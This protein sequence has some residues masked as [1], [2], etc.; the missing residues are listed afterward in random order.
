MSDTLVSIH[1][2]SAL[3]DAQRKALLQRTES[4]LSA[5]IDKV[6]PI[7]EAVRIDG[8]AALADFARQFDKAQVAADQ[9]RATTEEFSAARASIDPELI[10]TLEFAAGNIRH[11]HE[12]QMPETL[13]LHET[14]RGVLVGDRW[15]AIDSVACY[16]PRG[17]GS[18]PS[19]VLM[20]AIPAKVA[21]VRKVVIITPPGPDGTVDPATL[22]AA[23]IAG[24]SD[25]FKCGGAQ[26]IAAVAFGT[27]TVPKCDK[28]VGPG[29]PWVVAAKKQLSSL[30]DPGSPA[31]PSELIIFSDGSV[32]AELVALDLCVESEHGPDSSVFFVTDNADFANAVAS[33]VPAL[34]SRMGNIRAQYSKTVLSGPRGGIVIARTRADALA[35]V[36]DYAPEHLA[37]LA[38]NAWQYLAC[39]EHAG[40]ILLGPHSAISVANFVL[41]PSH[42]LPT[43]GAAKTT[44]PLSVFD[45]LKRTSIASLSKEAY[46]GFAAHAERLARYEGFDGHANAVST[47]RDEALRSAAGAST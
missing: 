46:G 15:N 39:F 8:D 40:E 23:E 26:A 20:T 36:N 47:I 5:F 33:C 6:N 44:S 3:D 34:W 13:V 7:I 35:F 21:G 1:T 2:L 43:G 32:P 45:F 27:Q 17:K 41:G 9:L 24:V 10:T 37:V 29:S 14:H 12:K 30:I 4:D 22:V 31:G 38:D 18:F 19:S 16:V 11:F 42:V 25:V 28:V